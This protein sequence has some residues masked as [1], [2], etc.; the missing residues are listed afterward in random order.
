M[1]E[2]W[3]A[4]DEHQTCLMRARESGKG[5]CSFFIVETDS[6]PI[7]GLKSC[8]NMEFIK[9]LMAIETLSPTKPTPITRCGNAL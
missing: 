9:L 1:R 5:G 3:Q 8:V 7:L 2:M 6:V 4:H